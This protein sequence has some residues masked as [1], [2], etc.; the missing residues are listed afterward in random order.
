MTDS[1]VFVVGC[2]KCEYYV[3]FTSKDDAKR[4]KEISRRMPPMC[5]DCGGIAIVQ[6]SKRLTFNE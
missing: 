4:F 2:Y 1:R 3:E 5:C 6:K